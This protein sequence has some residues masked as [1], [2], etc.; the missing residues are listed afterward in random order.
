MVRSFTHMMK[1]RRKRF[2]SKIMC[3]ANLHFFQGTCPS[4]GLAFSPVF[5]LVHFW[6]CGRSS[7]ASSWNKAFY[8]VVSVVFLMEVV[9][10]GL[11]RVFSGGVFFVFSFF[12]INHSKLLDCFWKNED[13]YRPLTYYSLQSKCC[14]LLL[15]K[16]NT[17]KKRCLCKSYKFTA[18]A[19]KVIHNAKAYIMAD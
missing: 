9:H 14:C 10:R 6:T 7:E 16:N 8:V 19:S 11:N 15:L 1:Y 18:H 5:I 12:M 17:W 2:L 3:I 4:P 13:D